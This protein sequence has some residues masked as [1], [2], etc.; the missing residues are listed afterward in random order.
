[1][2]TTRTV[3]RRL[4]Y[5][6]FAAHPATETERAMWGVELA[7]SLA[8]DT[9]DFEVYGL[10][11]MVRPGLSPE[12]LAARLDDLLDLADA[13]I[14]ADDLHLRLDACEAAADEYRDA[15]RRFVGAK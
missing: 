4:T 15:L 11:G 13:V 5:R 8:Y 6:A 12:Q 7:L 1:M 10:I 3:P 9:E 14:A 2:T